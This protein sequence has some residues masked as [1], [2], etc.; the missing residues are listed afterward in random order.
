MFHNCD[1][2]TNLTG[3][4]NWNTSKLK[5]MSYGTK[6][7]DNNYAAASGMFSFCDNLQDL[8]ALSDW[9]VSQVE[10]ITYLFFYC[11]KLKDLTPLSKWN[12]SN[13]VN[14]GGIFSGCSE[15]TSLHGLENWDFHHLTSLSV[16]D[17]VNGGAFSGCT[18]LENISALEKW[19][20]EDVTN[21]SS[22]FYN[23]DNLTDLSPIGK[24]DVSKVTE[25]YS[26][27]RKCS[28]LTDLTPLKK[29]DMSNVLYM[30]NM[31][32]DCSKLIDLNGIANWN[33]SNVT[34]MHHMFANCVDL[35]DV[36]ALAEWNMSKVTTMNDMFLNCNK[37]ARIGV[38]SVEHGGNLF[39]TH[40]KEYFSTPMPKLIEEGGN[41]H[42]NSW[43]D[44]L[45]EMS[46]H[47]DTYSTGMIYV[48]YEPSWIIEFNPNGGVGSQNSM[49]IPIDI[50][51]AELPDTSFL[52]FNYKF[53]GWTTQP[54]P[55]SDT[56]P[57][58][59]SGTPYRPSD[60]A[61]GKRYTLY[62]QWEKLGDVEDQPVTGQTGTL[63]GWIQIDSSN[64]K[65]DITPNGLQ[66]AIFTNKYDP[67]S[68]S[69]QFRFTKLKDGNVPD[70]TDDFRFELIDVDQN[71]TIQTVSNTG[72]A[73][74]FQPITYDK[75]ETYTYY[76]RE[77]PS[78]SANDVNDDPNLDYDDHVVEIVVTV[79]EEDDS[80]AESGRRLKATARITGDTTF[81]NDSKP[82][83]LDI[84]KTV[85]G[86]TDAMSGSHKDKEFQFNVQLLD[87]ENQP[88]SNKSYPMTMISITDQIDNGNDN[89]ARSIEDGSSDAGAEVRDSN[90]TNEVP[91]VI[92]FNETGNATIRLKADQQAKITGIPAYYKYTV[93]EID[94]PDD[95]YANVSLTNPSGVLGANSIVSVDAVN[96]Y[97]VQPVNVSL[98]AGKTLLAPGGLNQS[99]SNGEFQFVL[100]K[101]D[102][103]SNGTG[104]IDPSAAV[105]PQADPA[106]LPPIDKDENT[107]SSTA[108][109]DPAAPSCSGVSEA[110]NDG[111]GLVTFP[112]LS[113]T[114]PGVHEYQLREVKGDELDITYDPVVYAAKV[115]V[116]DNGSGRLTSQVTY[117]NQ[118][119]GTVITP[120]SD[121]GSSDPS[122]M[123]IPVFVNRSTVA[124]RLPVTGGNEIILASVILAVV[125]GCGFVVF[126]NRGRR[127]E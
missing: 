66:T 101:V 38:P 29:W 86:V 11:K 48:K 9:N 43:G 94:E 37:L 60:T 78:N 40:N 7:S 17:L 77:V 35:I 22:V 21:L 87:R 102:V 62:A 107:S 124:N 13:V 92:S 96:H 118:T 23:C 39:V 33:V 80:N 52:R 12:V 103:A 83:S 4:E 67:G 119:T 15:L 72:A 99:V 14:I 3:L 73:V 104:T 65:N 114:E 82:A 108:A 5:W 34:N 111:N 36:S 93:T 113:Y 26:A 98:Q 8:T 100:C 64:T 126:L 25:M 24:W 68:T 1:G 54:D 70:I 41:R 89:A 56:N 51:S 88:V 91:G 121:S 63:P 28:G 84:T 109:P 125:L 20:V 122:S 81:R 105:D 18:N 123:G 74:Q 16:G 90:P 46:A 85:T 97:T 47:P 58:L 50:T 44:L 6:F 95:G 2:L 110:S 106:G 61:D 116:T 32:L 71:K 115:T 112:Q 55:V 53:I 59:K 42:Y 117:T 27:F 10:D 30:N 49:T 19:N 31:F 45:N 120:T 69:V 79:T 75:A 57:L 127:E 76:V